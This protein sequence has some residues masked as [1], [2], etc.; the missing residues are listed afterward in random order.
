ME[1]IIQFKDYLFS[2]KPPPSKITVKN[3][4]SDIKKFIRWYE[5]VFR[6]NFYPNLIT[7]EIID[8][9]NKEVSQSQSIKSALRYLSSIRKFFAFLAVQKQIEVNPFEMKIMTESDKHTDRFNFRNFKN[10]LYITGSSP[11]TIKNY[12][13]D[14]RQFLE[15][16]DKISKPK[17]AWI[18]KKDNIYD[19]L[20]SNLVEEYKNRLI[21]NNLSPTSINRKLSS[22]RKYLSWCYKEGLISSSNKE[23]LELI[24]ALNLKRSSQ[25]NI[26]EQNL[27]STEAEI[28]APTL[29]SKIAPIRLS[30]KL[31]R[32]IDKTI[33]YTIVNPIIRILNDIQY[34]IW[35][36]KKK[37][38]F[39]SIS[40]FA[41][42]RK[43]LQKPDINLG[44]YVKN[45]NKSFYAP[46]STKHF[47]LHKKITYYLIHKRP[48][49]YKTYHL[50]PVSHYLHFAMLIIFASAL[51]FGLYQSLFQNPLERYQFAKA[52]SAFKKTKILS[53]K[54]KL[55]DS[56]GNP[57][58]SPTSL[59]F[60]IYNDPKASGSALLW[61]ELDQVKPDEN[62]EYTISLGNKNEIPQSIFTENSALWL[63][64]TIENK[65]E[66]IPR[67]R[68]V[69]ISLAQDA[70]SLEGLKLITNSGK[71]PLDSNAILALDSSGNL[72]IGGEIPHSF[73]AINSKLT[74]SG[75]ILSL[76][77]I[78]GSN[79]DIQVSPDG[80]GKIDL[81]KPL[82][83]STN[84]NNI[85]GIFGAVE[86]DD[87]FAILATSSAQSALNIN[88]NGLGPLISASSSGIAKFS[89]DNSGNT[90][91]A[92]DFSLSG[93][94]PEITTANETELSL[95]SKGKGILIL[96]PFS[97]GN[98]NFFSSANTLSSEGDLNIAGSLKVANSAVKSSFAGSLGVGENNPT[99]RLDIRESKTG[100]AAARIYN[101]S[102]SNDASGL[103]IKLGNTSSTTQASNK[104]IVFEQDGI[105]TVGM[106]RGKNDGSG[107]AYI[108]NG[109]SDFAEYIRKDKDQK[110][111]FGEVLCLNS[112][113]L[114]VPCNQN[115]QKIIGVASRN[116]GFLGGENL[117]ERSI[118]VG[119]IGIV[120]T[121]VTNI[122]G[123]ID[124]GD[125]L[126]S[127]EIPGYAMKATKEG[128]MIGRALQ[129]FNP[130]SCPNI[131]AANDNFGLIEENRICK[132]EILVL[133]NI[134]YQNPNP[135]PIQAINKILS[136]TQHLTQAV[137]EN[138]EAGIIKA[139]E[140]SADSI[141][142]ATNSVFINGQ[143][144]DDYVKNLISD[145]LNNEIIS[146][147]V[148]T[149]EL[150]T[151]II[152]PL[153][154][155]SSLVIKLASGSAGQD[156]SLVI[157]NSDNKDVAIINSK[158]EA[159]ISGRLTAQNLETN[160]LNSDNASINGTLRVNKIIAD[161][162][163]SL[164]EKSASGETD[165]T[166]LS[167]TN[168]QEIKEVLNLATFSAQLARI[169]ELKVA[170]A[171]FEQGFISLGPS[172]LSNV[173][174]V[175]K[176][177]VDSNLILA[178]RSINVLGN[179]LEFQ[180]LRQGGVSFLSGLIYIDTEGN[181]KVLGNAEFAKDLKIEGTLS[182]NLIAPI[183]D[184]D[185]VFTLKSSKNYNSPT[186]QIKNSSNSAVFSVNDKGDVISS[187]SG[188]FSKLNFSLIAP[189]L[190]ISEN[191]AIATG[192]AGIASIKAGQKE[193]TIFNK[194]VTDKS[195]I[196]ITPTVDTY[197]LVLYLIRQ[198]PGVSFTIGINTPIY[199]D[200]IFNWFI[201]N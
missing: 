133:L 160:Y 12:L 77:T 137:I 9:F 142:I 4:V 194:S 66:L 20:N 119:L 42:K 103:I 23:D 100:T 164:E 80:L 190:A 52:E 57:I 22:I 60:A 186:F 104:W 180:P 146:P 1:F 70:K 90:M 143:S 102:V 40:F 148:K 165:L 161:Q 92:G 27:A 121:K 123:P 108:D 131:Q 45:I 11:L 158:G 110:I 145:N 8:I 33:D 128:M 78:F 113:G 32:L 182:A 106:I 6:N 50:L 183:P 94:S 136:E 38:I 101:N 55:T 177:S 115:S 48:K 134:G 188:T 91:I 74:L 105:G 147:I 130:V 117:G 69:N 163:Q 36:L 72:S 191:E 5:S 172:S 144:L 62:G 76:S 156:S 21:Q 58:T 154:K 95:S 122:N 195:L 64:I 44:P 75:N 16:T 196:Y 88:Q 73:Q 127:S 37:P 150:Y 54:Q 3:Y 15:W 120:F 25:S 151:N 10:Y 83:N 111:D 153:S 159:S 149:E 47:P 109:I 49:W 97:S 162:I 141:R 126:T 2:Q 178:N 198:V 174:I 124:E 167:Q 168:L 51:G 19:K 34:V 152:S 84:N 114:A 139:R 132:G 82:Q 99:Y 118:P 193:I 179:D 89:V 17:E 187:G 31:I 157:K 59:R 107:I 135:F 155:D 28:Y 116:P 81:Q 18:V 29:Y 184:Q 181:L 169:D 98:I 63:G 129:K 173:S 35:K 61:E 138:L 93:S 170:T 30:Q 41:K 125:F 26:F 67:Q 71:E 43:F 176:L 201:L 46:I 7:P 189:A 200:I 65:D 140:I 171:Y 175:G 192:S 24:D 14:I 53:F 112:V 199:K 87:L 13:N 166:K 68:L 39:I 56:L 86:V 85:S 79:S 197:N 96:Q 185:L